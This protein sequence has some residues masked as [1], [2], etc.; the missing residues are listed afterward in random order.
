MVQNVDRKDSQKRISAFHADVRVRKRAWQEETVSLSYFPGTVERSEP[1]VKG[2]EKRRGFLAVFVM[3]AGLMAGYGALLVQG[4]L[5]LLPPRV[6]PR[7]RR[8]FVGKV[9]HYEVGGVKR[10]YDLRGN[11]ILVKRKSAEKFQAFSSRCPHL[12]C[13]VHWQEKENRFFCPCHNGVF[14]P[15]GKAISGPPAKAGQ[16]L[17]PVPI[18]VDRSSG[19]VYIE[20]KDVRGKLV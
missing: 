14:D 20:V 9:D 1:K 6:K 8:L 12:G 7:T 4:I 5:F 15:D 11:L 18:H 3:A 10:V 17:N 2:E 13:R 16:R 19:R